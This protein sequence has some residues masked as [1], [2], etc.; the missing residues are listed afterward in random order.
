MQGKYSAATDEIEDFGNGN[1][2]RNPGNPER[3]IEMVGKI[4]NLCPERVG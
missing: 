3:T 4:T 1:G 2:N